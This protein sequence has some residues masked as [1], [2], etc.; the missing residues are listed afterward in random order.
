MS[1]RKSKH[2]KILLSEIFDEINEIFDSKIPTDFKTIDYGDYTAYEFTTNS[3]L[4]YDLEFHET[5][6][7]CDTVLNGEI[8]LG[9][10][11]K[12]ECFNENRIFGYDIAFT[13][14]STNDKDNPDEF[15]KET[16]KFE[17]IEVMARIAYII[18]LLIKNH[19]DVKLFIIGYAKRNKMKIYNMLYEK[20]FKNNFDLYVGNSQFHKGES[21]FIIRKN[22]R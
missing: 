1:P 10:I 2:N 16:N 9:E 22:K 15:E 13:L 14:S 3:G 17:Q 6:E 5:Y 12:D 19:T 4:K 7:Y 11:L 18:D 8:A 21:F 20:H